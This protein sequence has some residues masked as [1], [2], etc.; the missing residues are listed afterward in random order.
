MLVKVNNRLWE[1]C[2]CVNSLRIQ[3]CEYRSGK[4][5]YIA[6]LCVDGKELEYDRYDFREEAI[7]AMDRLA[8][9]INAKGFRANEEHSTMEYI[10]HGDEPGVNIYRCSRCK[11]N[12]Q[13]YDSYDYCPYCGRKV[14]EWK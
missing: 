2:Y 9:K 10:G 8:S 5:E 6:Y 14:K 7:E 1:N 4:N 12:V 11:A 13:A 3:R